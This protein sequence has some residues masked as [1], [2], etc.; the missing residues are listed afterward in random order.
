MYVEE[1]GRGAQVEY[2][3]LVIVAC[4]VRGVAGLLRGACH[5]CRRT[6]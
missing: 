3:G 5:F 2:D 6:F 1:R 4:C